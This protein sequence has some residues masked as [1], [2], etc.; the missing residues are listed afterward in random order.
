[1]EA[2]EESSELQTRT[3]RRVAMRLMPV[4]LG[5]YVIAYLDRVNVTFARDKLESDLGFSGAVH[6]FTRTDTAATPAQPV[7]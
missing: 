7:T 6:G 3:I 2:R 4:L 5:H 1:M